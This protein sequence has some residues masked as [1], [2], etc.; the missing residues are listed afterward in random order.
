MTTMAADIST[1]L[2]AVAGPC[3]ICGADVWRPHF[4]GLIDHL[5]GERFDVERCGG[6]AV[7]ATRPPPPADQVGRF[8]P[9]RYRGNRHAFTGGLRDALRRRAVEARFPKGFRGRLLD[10]G[11]GSGAFARH[12]RARGWDVAA[13]EIDAGTVERL[14][15]DGIDAKLPAE[16]DATGFAGGP[17]NAVT[18]WH[19]ME[20]VEHP[21]ALARWV[22]TQLAPGGVFQATVP[23]VASWQARLFGRRWMH[24]DVPRHRHHFTPATFQSLLGAS[25]LTVEGRANVALE[26]DWFGVIQTALDVACSR[27]N[28]LFDRLTSA[29]EAGRASALDMAVSAALAG[30]LAAVALPP[31]VVGWAV[32]DGAT[33]TLT[34]R[35]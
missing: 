23:N 35:R 20:H 24:L 3:A 26:Y 30:P 6:C 28:V 17:F 10:V 27:P 12:M 5:T 29:P 4:Q 21:A 7:L 1:A 31:L 14:R 33:L 34:C 25:G 13:T 2:V 8:Y 16:A 11:C 15:A 19:V 9:P 32:G 18:C 22:A